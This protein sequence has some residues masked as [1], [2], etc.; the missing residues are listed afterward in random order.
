MAIQNNIFRNCN[1]VNQTQILQYNDIFFNP[2]DIA[3]YDGTCWIDTEVLSF[4]TP[5]ADVTFNGYSSCDDCI[6]NNLIG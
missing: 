1:D 3:Y 2:G 6:S 5:V 4:L